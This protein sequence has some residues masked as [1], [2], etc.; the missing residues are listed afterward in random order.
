NR[1]K[2][3]RIV[4]LT[5]EGKPLD[6]DAEYEIVLNNYRA[7]GGG[8]YEMFKGKPVVREVLIEMAEL[9]SNYVLEKKEIEA[10]V[11]NNWGAYIEM[12]YTV[13]SGETLESVASKLGIPVEDIKR[14]N[15]VEEVKEGDVLK[16]YVPYF[17]YL[18]L[19]QKAS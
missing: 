9:M 11:D 7:G 2:G 19:M 5:F 8:G 3:D 14:W 13:H 12:T 16:Y 18:K 17:E 4:D 1:P 10:T 15:N 6:M